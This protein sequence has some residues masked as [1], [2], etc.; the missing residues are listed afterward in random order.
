M[1][2]DVGLYRSLG[3]A[4][5]EVEALLILHY[6][7]VVLAWT[8]PKACTCRGGEPAQQQHRDRK[9]TPKSLHHPPY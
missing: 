3:I 9:T 1:L 5:S 2:Y 6:D 7:Y 8:L 4:L